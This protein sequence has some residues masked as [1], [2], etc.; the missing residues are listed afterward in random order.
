MSWPS[1]DTLASD[2]RGRVSFFAATLPG[3]GILLR[4]ES[5]A[6]GALEP[7]G[8]IGFDGRADLVFFRVRRGARFPLDGLRLAEDVFVV[9]LLGTLQ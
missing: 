2:P 6:Q 3:L 8:D 9:M 1:C 5:A 4:D 7:E